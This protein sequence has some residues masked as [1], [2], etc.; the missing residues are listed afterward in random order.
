MS[1]ISISTGVPIMPPF[2]SMF[3][4]YPI[5]LPSITVLNNL[6]RAPFPYA[7][8]LQGVWVSAQAII[9][10]NLT[11]TITNKAAQTVAT[12]SLNAAGI[13][14]GTILISSI[15]ANEVLSVNVT[16]IGIG[17]ANVF[18]TLWIQIL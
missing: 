6:V 12:V 8:T 4:P 10:G 17:L 11:M 9:S 2:P 5:A 15:A 14:T 3:V 7:C 1:G 13:V 16:G 18:L